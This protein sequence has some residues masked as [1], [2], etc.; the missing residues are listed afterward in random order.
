MVNLNPVK[1]TAPAWSSTEICLVATLH[2]NLRVIFFQTSPLDGCLHLIPV[3]I[4]KNINV[5]TRETRLYSKLDWR[6][7]KHC[8]LVVTP[9][10]Q[11]LN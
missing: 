6:R 11:L 1:A 8:D 7:T 3:L 5:I 4:S 10:W 9:A 2:K